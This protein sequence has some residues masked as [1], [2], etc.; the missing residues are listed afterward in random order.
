[1]DTDIK[2]AL[3]AHGKAVDEAMAKYEGQLREHGEVATEA[4]AEVK[5]LAEK[6]EAAV[7]EIAQKLEGAKQHEASKLSAGSE[8]VKS[9]GFKQLVSGQVQRTRLE[10][11]NT[12][13]SDATTTFPDQRPG[14]IPGDFAPTTIREA[15]PSIT[16]TGNMVNSLREDAWTN[17]AREVTQGDAKPESDITFEA[18]NVPIETVAHF[19][20][21]SV[22]LLADA[23]AVAAYIDR[24]LRDGLAQRVDRQLLLGNGTTPNLSGLTDSGN[25]TA[26]TSAS[27]DNIVDAINKAKYSLW[28]I[29]NSPDTAIVNPAD[30]GAMERLREGGTGAYLY[31]MPGVAAGRNP[32]G[33]N[34]VLSNHMPAGSFLIGALRTSTMV[35]TRQ[36]TTIEMGYV[37]ADF[38]NNVVTIRAE[39]RLGLAVDRPTGIMYGDY[40]S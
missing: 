1:M 5:A 39:E 32:F 24:R 21:V 36:G 18:Y 2:S 14:V 16:V 8:F 17:S 28:A 4:K 37:N 10:V 29:G 11:K 7:T 6:F 12:V 19:I 20:K 9:E 40:E 15:L 31:G 38:T 22:Q 35:Y 27:N 26:Y 25:F 23:P 33:V 34:V 3:D 30:W 13:L